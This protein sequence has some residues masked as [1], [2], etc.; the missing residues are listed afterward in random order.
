MSGI[1]VILGSVYFAGGLLTIDNLF[2]VTSNML[3]FLTINTAHLFQDYELDNDF[4]EYGDYG[5]FDQD[6]I[7]AGE[8]GSNFM[9]LFS[10][11]CKPHS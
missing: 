9:L 4:G 1:W 7:K 8:V 10:I 2:E 3:P 5:D 11:H 6:M